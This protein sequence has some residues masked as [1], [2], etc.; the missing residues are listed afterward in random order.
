[1][2]LDSR[3][4]IGQGARRRCATCNAPI[5]VKS[6][7]RTRKFC[8]STC[9]DIAR[10]K[11]NFEILGRARYPRQGEPR[12]LE[13]T[14]TISTPKIDVLADR[15]S[16][17]KAPPIVT[18]GLGCHAAP[19]ASEQSTERAANIRNAIRVELKARWPRG[20]PHK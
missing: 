8:S 2:L 4:A 13:K 6:T 15:G 12:N 10:R 7:G 5:N 17:A 1:M 9:R 18:V 19:Q 20:M 11:A 16:A 14:P 3:A